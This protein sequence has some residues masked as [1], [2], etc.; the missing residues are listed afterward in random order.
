MTSGSMWLVGASARSGDLTEVRIPRRGEGVRKHSV[1]A[2]VAQDDDC[3]NARAAAGRVIHMKAVLLVEDN[4]DI[5][6]LYGAVLRREGY[7]VHEAENGQEALDRLHQMKGNPCLVLLDLMMPIMSGPELLKVLH[8]S[9]RLAALPV[10]VLSAG[11]QESEAPEAKKFIRK[12]VDSH[13][14]LTV[15]KEFCGP[16]DDH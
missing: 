11:G 2:L 16:A 7:E 10:V 5:R 3:R 13:L 9:H 8:E 12:P 4:D 1:G 15:V 14:L 6:E